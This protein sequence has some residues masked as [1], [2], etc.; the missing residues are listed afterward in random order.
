MGVLLR[1][2]GEMLQGGEG[3]LVLE[4]EDAFMGL[5][6]LKVKGHD[7]VV[8]RLMLCKGVG[9]LGWILQRLPDGFRGFCHVSSVSLKK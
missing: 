1:R 3:L 2:M 4:R 6:D 5:D 9:E 7:T 8:E